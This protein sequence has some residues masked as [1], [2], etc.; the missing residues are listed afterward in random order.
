MNEASDKVYQSK[1]GI[2]ISRL[3]PQAFG[4][5]ALFLGLIFAGS[6]LHAASR[7][8]ELLKKSDAWFA[9]E[10]GVA[11][12]NNILSW[13]TAHGD[14]PKNLNTTLHARDAGGKQ[15][16]GTFDNGATS[17][18]LRVLA[19]AFR[20]TGDERYRDAFLRGFDHILAAQYP[21]GGWPQFYPLSRDYHRHITFNDGTMI[22]LME[23]LR[24]ASQAPDFAF[25]D[26]ERR[27]AAVAA[28][29]R[30]IECIVKCQV[31]IDGER[32][33]WCAQHD[34]ETLAPAQARS[35]ELPTL[36]GAE[37]AGILR[38]LM[39]IEQPSTEVIAA[40]NAGARWFEATRIHGYRY[41]RSK[42]ERTLV[43]DPDAP[44]LWARFYELKTNRPVF[45][46]RD[47]VLKNSLD[48]I[49]SERRN[50]Y[51]WYGP[52]GNNVL[53][54]YTKWPHRQ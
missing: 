45:S 27:E 37:S 28:V 34:A 43:E 26:H 5:A 47:G 29:E 1:T 30:G 53:K 40:V 22:R 20:L 13:Q 16:K 51:A 44:P 14:W 17:G 48:E 52:W 10:E 42:T 38:F 19:R 6:S 39:R 35:Y 21:G 32:T 4:L 49:G 9:S 25:L 23:F 24:D 2:V 11:A 12:L 46:D 3:S 18:E 31:V 7:A 50:G 15:P 33:V 54:S 41:E 8:D 36:S